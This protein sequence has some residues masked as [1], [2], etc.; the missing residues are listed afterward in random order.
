MS[1][2]LDPLPAAGAAAGIPA[3]PTATRRRWSAERGFYLGLTAAITTAVVLGF[4]RTFFFRA[5][6]PEWAQAHGAP[7]TFFYVHGVVFAAWYLLALVNRNRPQSHKRY[8]L[9]GSIAIAEAGV[10]RWPFAFMSA[11]S[12]VPG[13]GMV[14]LC[15]DLFLIPM[16]VWDLA[17]RRRVHPVTLWGGLVLIASQPLRM[18]LSA[19]PVW[20]A[21]A[22]WA[23]NLIPH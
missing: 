23:V 10:G 1:E 14:E 18:M 13:F 4:A 8:M 2:I 5:W 11:A 7:E 15:L 19:T 21:F 3:A 22:G 9:L 12:P 20:L 17:T 16:I 6:Y